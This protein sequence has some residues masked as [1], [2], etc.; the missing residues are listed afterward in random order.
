MRLLA[1]TFLIVPLSSLSFA[2]MKRQMRFDAILK[3]TLAATLAQN[4][5]A[6]ALALVGVGYMSLA[7]GACAGVVATVVVSLALRSSEMP[8]IP[9]LRG[10]WPILK[11]GGTAASGGIVT[12]LGLSAPDLVMGRMLGFG[13]VGIYSRATG[14]VNL[15]R[16]SVGGAVASVA[17]PAFAERHRESEPLRDV[18]LRSV[19]LVT[20]LAWPFYG[21]LGIMAFPI[22]R[23]FYG[24]QWDAAVPLVQI[25]CLAFALET[26][27]TFAG[28][29]FLAMGDVGKQLRAQLLLQPLRFVLVVVA[30]LHSV[31]AVAAVQ[32]LF[33]LIVAF[34]YHRMLHVHI[35]VTAT[36]LL[37]AL[38][39]SLL[40][41]VLALA[42]VLAT[43]LFFGLRSTQIW[44]P[45]ILGGFAML[46]AWLAAIWLFRPPIYHELG[47][48]IERVL[49]L[50]RR[51]RR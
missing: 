7:W 48:L 29:T 32:V 44:S 18:Y 50:W 47:G 12:N 31:A 6:V 8:W 10:A 20:A 17:M 14:L 23:I 2:L 36:A 40:V 1:L 28:S 42:P 21:F 43:L 46:V 19:S 11:F 30:S 15:F 27:M 34:I 25:L 49:P 16:L 39:G 22:V 5:T 38:R 35:G 41:T 26:V 3:I 51:Q 37:R 4:V 13:E 9:S 45:P 33:Y 24:P